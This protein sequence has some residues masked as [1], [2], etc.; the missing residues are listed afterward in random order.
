VLVLKKKSNIKELSS[1]SDCFWQFIGCGKAATD[2][3]Q[4][5]HL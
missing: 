5:P 3:T 2:D 1:Q 4:P